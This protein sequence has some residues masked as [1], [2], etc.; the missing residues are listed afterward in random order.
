MK[1]CGNCGNIC[2]HAFLLSE[3]ERT[4]GNHFFRLPE[5]FIR[6]NVIE[7]A[8]LFWARK[9]YYFAFWPFS[10]I[11]PS[12]ERV[13]QAPKLERETSK[14]AKDS[15]FCLKNAPN[16]IVGISSIWWSKSSLLVKILK[17]PLLHFSMYQSQFSMSQT[18]PVI[19][20]LNSKFVLKYPVVK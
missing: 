18:L 10:I 13:H 11:N 8:F 1:I 12:T 7:N 6:A 2:F 14:W 17:F 19:S 15:R 5:N 3:T 16:N 20:F 4:T 9:T